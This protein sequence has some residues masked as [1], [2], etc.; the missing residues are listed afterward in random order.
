M[1]EAC[2]EILSSY[3]TSN[4]KSLGAI[5]LEISFNYQLF[6]EEYSREQSKSEIGLL[7]K[8]CDVDQVNSQLQDVADLFYLNIINV[9][10]HHTNTCREWYWNIQSVRASSIWNGCLSRGYSTCISSHT[11]SS[12]FRSQCLSSSNIR[13]HLAVSYKF[14]HAWCVTSP[15][16]LVQIKSCVLVICSEIFADVIDGSPLTMENL[17]ITIQAFMYTC[18]L[19]IFRLKAV[20]W[21]P[22]YVS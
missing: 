3:V 2:N 10:F 18:Q 6:L 13:R 15:C 7:K 12:S 14:Y 22:S 9:W 11:S 5:D 16:S 17:T 8:I 19:Q 4:G 21:S 20:T 1:P